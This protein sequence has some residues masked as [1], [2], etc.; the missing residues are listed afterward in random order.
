[1]SLG[2]LTG[3]LQ[4]PN[5][6]LQG[7]GVGNVTLVVNPIA[8]TILVDGERTLT[9]NLASDWEASCGTLEVA[10]DNLSAVYTAPDT[11][12]DCTI[13]V[14]QIGDEGNQ[15]EVGV[16][17]IS[18][19]AS[20]IVY[21]GGA[22]TLI[23]S[24]HPGVYSGAGGGGGGSPVLLTG[25][26]GGWALTA[27][28]EQTLSSAGVVASGPLDL[29][30]NGAAT[31]GAD[32]VVLNGTDQYLSKTS[33]A[34]I[35]IA[36]QTQFFISFLLKTA[37]TDS[38]PII[39]K[40]GAS[41]IEWAVFMDKAG[42]NTGIMLAMGEDGGGL[43][44]DCISTKYPNAQWATG[45]VCFAWKNGVDVYTSINDDTPVTTSFGFSTFA[46]TNPMRLGFDDFYG[47]YLNG[48]VINP[49]I[50]AGSNLALVSSAA[51]RTWLCNGGAYRTGAEIAAY[52][53]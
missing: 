44:V 24:R 9:A 47:V 10:G 20:G 27:G 52:T 51:Y 38:V 15:V 28:P 6:L 50:W 35:Q 53:G 41:E 43:E 5:L 21:S 26:V 18:Q 19:F 1:M 36:T 12:G 7:Y 42:A 34:A 32:G 4:S 33:A 13:T 22:G 46:G 17:V 2:L 39:T 30:N 29:T 37:A 48:S 3:G 11:P 16:R 23:D 8:I 31:F 14:T 49:C 40:D 45:K 25:L